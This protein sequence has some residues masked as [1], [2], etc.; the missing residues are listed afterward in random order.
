VSSQRRSD[1][2]DLELDGQ[3]D[4]RCDH[5]AWVGVAT[6]SETGPRTMNHAGPMTNVTDPGL[7]PGGLAELA[8]A[9]RYASSGMAFIYQALDIL[10]S[11]YGLVDAV[12]V[13]D[14]TPVGRQAFRLGRRSS[15]G[16]P[17]GPQASWVRA[18]LRGPPGLHSDPPIVDRD[19][20][21]FVS[22]MAVTALRMDLLA[23]D[24]GHDALTGLLNRRSYELALAEAIGRARRYGWPFSV[25]MLDLDNFKAVNDRLGHAAGDDALRVIGS[26]VRATLRSGDVAARLGGDEFALLVLNADA[27]DVLHPLAERLRAALDRSEATS[28]L[29]FSAGVASFPEDAE[30]AETLQRIADTRLYADK[31][32]VA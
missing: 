15:H 10:A 32:S 23:H 18:A 22:D 12:L 26:E 14:D 25:V 17:A 3:P 19:V 11:R 31:A 6:V 21:M 5:A 27:T 13:L 29:R 4:P 2:E 20:C 8:G 28:G 30:D 7:A 1:P 9:L 16:T 24:A